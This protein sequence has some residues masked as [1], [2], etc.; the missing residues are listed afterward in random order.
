M[1]LRNKLYH[2]KYFIFEILIIMISVCSKD[3]KFEIR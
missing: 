2:S 3:Y 1:L